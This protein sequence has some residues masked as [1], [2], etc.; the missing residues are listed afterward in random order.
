MI[1][2]GA[3]CTTVRSRQ[4]VPGGPLQA[5]GPPAGRVVPRVPRCRA[6]W[7]LGIVGMNRT[8]R[9][10]GH[11]TSIIPIKA[12]RYASSLFGAAPQADLVGWRC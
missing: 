5:A 10:R 7:S 4:R 2:V 9:I 6:F 12:S 8:T 1:A 3:S 11:S